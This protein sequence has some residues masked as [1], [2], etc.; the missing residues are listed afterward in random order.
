MEEK[1]SKII[2]VLEEYL[3][4]T[5]EEQLKKDW[6]ELEQYNQY[7]PEM[8]EC[9][10]FARQHYMEMMKNEDDKLKEEIIEKDERII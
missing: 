1:K 6:A 8:T 9:L 4:N 5:S 10:K 2:Q 3:A 7:G